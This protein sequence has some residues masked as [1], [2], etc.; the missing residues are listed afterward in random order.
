LEAC[1]RAAICL[2][3]LTPNLS[4]NIFIQLGIIDA[5]YDISDRTLSLSHEF[6]FK[7]LTEKNLSSKNI[8]NILEGESKPIFERILE[9]EPA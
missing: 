2:A 9:K 5:D 4:K 1:R 7:N 8:E 6:S 3:A